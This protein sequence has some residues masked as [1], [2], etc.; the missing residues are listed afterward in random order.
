MK[1]IYSK[2]IIGFL[3]TSLLSF[4]ICCFFTIRSYNR[5]SDQLALEE[6]EHSSNHIADLIKLIDDKNQDKILADYSETSEMSFT[7]TCEGQTKSYGHV[8]KKLILK[9]DELKTLATSKEKSL[10][11]EGIISQYAKAFKIDNQTYVIT[12]Q[13]DFSATKD[14]FM[15]SYT[16]AAIIFMMTGS[17]VF[18]IVADIIVKPIS[19]LTKV[20]DELAKGNYKVRV[21]YE[22][23]DE[24]SSLYAS[25]NQMAVRLA[26]QET[27]RQQFISDV[28]H[29]FQTPLTAISGFATILKNENLTD[30]QRQK[31]ADII[32][33]NSNRLSHLSKN[34]LQLTLL[35]GEDTSLDKSEFPLIEQLNRVIEME[36][37]AAL[38]KDI[39]IEFIHP[40]KEFIIEADESRMEQVWINLLSNA[41]KYTN[42]H[43]VVTVEVRRTPTELQVRFEDTGVGMSQDAISH[44][45]ERFYRQDKSRT[46]EGNGLGLSIVKRIIDLHHYKI[47][48]ESQEDVGSVFTVYIPYEMFT[49]LTKKK[50]D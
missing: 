34:M 19:R 42:E 6:L 40:K 44:I 21:N 35:D 23:K 49:G 45:F 26:K 41:I 4:S 7:V 18:L 39:E 36:D 10:R 12:V 50:K 38:S 22:G 2:L 14:I 11:S 33:F 20:T 5:D 15:K 25:F 1:S 16:S 9:D 48:V 28:S 24:I 8:N 32:L 31:Y 47:D 27:I 37:N 3:L 13:K 30:E 43:G 46:I 29:E 17:I